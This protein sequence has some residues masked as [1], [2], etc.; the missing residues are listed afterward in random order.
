M[1]PEV[2]L[3][4]LRAID[5]SGLRPGREAALYSLLLSMALDKNYIDL[6][7]D[8]VIAPAA[9]YY[10]RHG[11][12]YHRFLARFYEGRI[13]ENAG[14]YDDALARYLSAGEVAD[15]TVP[16]DYMVRLLFACGR[17]YVRQFAHDK[18]LEESLKAMTLS[19]DLENPQFF[20]RS[21]L[22]AASMYRILNKPEESD[23]CLDTL[24]RWL[25]SR[26]LEK[27]AAYHDARL[28]IEVT[29]T[30]TDKDLISRTLQDYREASARQ[31]VTADPVL[32]AKAE[33]ALSNTHEART[34]MDG[35]PDPGPDAGFQTIDYCSTISAIEDALGNHEASLRYRKQYEAAVEAVNLTVFN[36]DVRFLE[37]RHE[38]EKH[39]EAA[40]RRLI[41]TGSALL[42]LAVAGVVTFLLYLRRKKLYEKSLREAGAE[43]EFIKNM[44]SNGREGNKEYEDML[45]ARLLALKPHLERTG[46]GRKRPSNKEVARLA[47]NRTKMLESIA[48]MC[49]LTHPR[50]TSVLAGRGLT[51]E[52]IGLCSL[53]V[54]DYRP[55]ELPDILGKGSIYHRNTEIRSKLGDLVEG[56]TLPV[57]LRQLFDRKETS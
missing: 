32:T 3:A 49:A 38:D 42:A 43:Y 20:V 45:R 50:F 39:R 29:N 55:Q 23:A 30:A 16:Q 27:P 41:L 8:S 48:L 15:K 21:A 34:I 14:D 26:G 35:V 9:A 13:H 51:A 19:E 7:S 18:A 12:G 28:R 22:D 36:N 1:K 44:L 54:S 25:E 46:I 2:A 11:D 6:Q 10:S 47:E 52:E 53:Y 5:K 56:T 57:W 31:G 37:E 24:S 4:D 33:L 40:R 17:I